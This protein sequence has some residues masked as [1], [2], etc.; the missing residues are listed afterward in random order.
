KRPPQAGQADRGP[1]APLHAL[2]LELQGMPDAEIAGALDAVL[3]DLP[4]GE[5]R[6]MVDHVLM[7]LESREAATA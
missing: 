1:S 2:L 3:A 6:G 5:P 4:N 7:K